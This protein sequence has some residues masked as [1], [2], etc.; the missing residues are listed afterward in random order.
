M[1]THVAIKFPKKYTTD[2]FTLSRKNKDSLSTYVACISFTKRF[3]FNYVRKR[4]Q[5]SFCKYFRNFFSLVRKHEN[6]QVGLYFEYG[7]Y[8]LGNIIML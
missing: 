4:A 7:G 8:N 5:C 6:K 2:N 1:K 3:A